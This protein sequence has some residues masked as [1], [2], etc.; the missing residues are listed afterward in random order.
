MKVILIVPYEGYSSN[1][2]DE[3]YSSNVPDEGYSDRT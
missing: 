1:V 3:G 2:P